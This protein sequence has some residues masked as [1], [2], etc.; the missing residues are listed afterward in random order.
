M[1]FINIGVSYFVYGE[2]IDIY[3]GADSI[4]QEF[5]DAGVNYI[6]S[7][8]EIVYALPLYKLY[9]T[10]AY[11]D[12]E[13]SVRRMQRAGMANI[14]RGENSQNGWSRYS[15]TSINSPLPFKLQRLS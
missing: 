13:K 8:A 2:K 6:R 15:L 5:I 12:Y 3:S 10:K 9:P 4:Q 1:P 14:H 7:A 11:K